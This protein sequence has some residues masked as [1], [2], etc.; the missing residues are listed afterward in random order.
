[1]TKKDEKAKEEA[2]E[3]I[4]RYEGTVWDFDTYIKILA[5]ETNPKL[6]EEDITWRSKSM[7]D[8]HK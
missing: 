3:R 5:K 1:M 6:K 8:E 7:E 4:R 2:K